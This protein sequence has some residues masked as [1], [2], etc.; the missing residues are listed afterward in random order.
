VLG[1]FDAAFTAGFEPA[2]LLE[3][4]IGGFQAPK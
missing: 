4:K 1:L 3:Q 2:L